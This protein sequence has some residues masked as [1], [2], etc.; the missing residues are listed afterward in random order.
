MPVSMG[1]SSK[2]VSRSTMNMKARVPGI[3][4]TGTGIM[5]TSITAKRRM[6]DTMITTG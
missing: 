1:M 6:P 5:G 3:P 2:A 4:M